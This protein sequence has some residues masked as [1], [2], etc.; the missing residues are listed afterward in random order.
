MLQLLPCCKTCKT[1]STFNLT[2]DLLNVLIGIREERFHNAPDY[3][4]SSHK[5]KDNN[6]NSFYRTKNIVYCPLN[7]RLYWTGIANKFVHLGDKSTVEDYKR[8]WIITLV[9]NL[10]WN[11]L[12]HMF[13]DYHAIFISF[14][15]WFYFLVDVLHFAM[16][17]VLEIR[18]KTA[19]GSVLNILYTTKI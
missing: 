17:I 1:P 19:G 11:A 18:S 14:Q 15:L 12:Y 8:S 10:K 5:I 3:N 9:R 13:L 7:Y 6:T 2:S 16:P 4:L